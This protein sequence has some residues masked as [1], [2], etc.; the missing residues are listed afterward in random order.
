MYIF[1]HEYYDEGNIDI[2]KKERGKQ[3]IKGERVSLRGLE[4]NDIPMFLLYWNKKEFMDY[5]GRTSPV[6]KLE[7]IEWIKKTWHDR[8]DKES[9]T[10]A[11]VYR[12]NAL[13]IGYISIKNKNTISRRAGLSIGIFIPELRNKGLGS[14]ALKLILNYCF[15]TLNLLSIELNVFTNNPRAISC[16]TKLG[17]QSIGIRRKADFVDNEYLDDLMMDLLVEE[18][19]NKKYPI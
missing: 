18:W 10:F 1:K 19:K 13:V 7:L 17:F 14:E 12:E 16:Y 6:T 15:N 9:Y 3:V 5:T 11:I 8:K 4:L 2:K